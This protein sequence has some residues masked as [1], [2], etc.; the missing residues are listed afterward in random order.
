MRSVTVDVKL[1][2][3]DCVSKKTATFLFFRINNSVKREPIS[4][5]F[6]IL[7]PEETLHQKVVK[8]STSPEICHRTT[9]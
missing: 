1:N 4:I 3:T 9:L 6:G 8:L 5:I 7:S 2:Y